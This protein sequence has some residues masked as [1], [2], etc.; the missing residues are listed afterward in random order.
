MNKIAS[1][2]C[3]VLIS[4][5]SMLS[6]AQPPG[7]YGY[8]AAGSAPQSPGGFSVQRG[9]S[10]ERNRDQAG[11]HLRIHLQG[12]SPDAI[13]TNLQGRTLVVENRESHQVEQRNDRG[14]YQ[15]SSSSSSMRR[16]FPLPPDADAQAMKRSDEEGVIV[17]TFPYA[18]QVRY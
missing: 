2:I 15:F 12:I 7:S 13:Q 6:L 11:Y 8:G 14:S 16:R 18:G 5:A 3:A 1:V 9:M 10:F 4:G 17:V